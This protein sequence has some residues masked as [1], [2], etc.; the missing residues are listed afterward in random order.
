MICPFMSKPIVYSTVESGGDQ[1]WMLYE[2]VCLKEHC[3]AWKRN[4]LPPMN[5][6]CELIDGIR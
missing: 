1:Q 3:M 6:F 4:T 2:V 5:G